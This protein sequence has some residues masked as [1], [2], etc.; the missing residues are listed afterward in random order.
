MMS[1]ILIQT[2]IVILWFSRDIQ[3]ALW[4]YVDSS[5]RQI[6]LQHKRAHSKVAGR[7]VEIFVWPHEVRS[8]IQD[9]R[10]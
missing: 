3:K 4:N 9:D 1:V 8:R 10:W 6:Y 2:R 5:D 7:W